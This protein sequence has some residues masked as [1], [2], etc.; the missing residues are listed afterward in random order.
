MTTAPTI[1]RKIRRNRQTPLPPAAE[2]IQKGNLVWIKRLNQIPSH[3]P[4]SRWTTAQV[5]AVEEG[6]RICGQ[7]QW[8]RTVSMIQSHYPLDPAIPHAVIHQRHEGLN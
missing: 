8:A 6:Q 5:A 2:G 7:R 4:N 3:H 1:R